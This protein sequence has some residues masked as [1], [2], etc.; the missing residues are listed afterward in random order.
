VYPL[1]EGLTVARNQWYIAAWSVE[2]T[3]KPMERWLLNEPVVFYRAEGG[4]P[5]AVSG[6]CPHRGFPLGKS[7]VIGED[8]QCSYHG[9]IFRPDGSCTSQNAIPVAC[10]IKSYSIVEKWKW[11]WIWMGDTAKADHSLIP[12]WSDGSLASTC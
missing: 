12:Y 9:L 1:L 3:R 10:R 7:R 6:R 8:V 4:E 11:I 2:V 5:V